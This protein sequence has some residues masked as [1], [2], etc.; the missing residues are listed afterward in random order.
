[1]ALTY[2]DN[3]RDELDELDSYVY[4]VLIDHEE[5]HVKH[6]IEIAKKYEKIV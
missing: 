2:L 1:M 4:D 3:I 5:D 6:N